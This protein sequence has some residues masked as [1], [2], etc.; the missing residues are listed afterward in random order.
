MAAVRAARRQ[1][2][3]AERVVG[4]EVQPLERTLARFVDVLAAIN[5]ERRYEL[6][7]L[8]EAHTALLVE[9][10]QDRQVIKLLEERVVGL[11]WVLLVAIGVL[12]I[13]GY[14]ALTSSTPFVA[15]LSSHAAATTTTTAATVANTTTH[16]V[17][18]G[19]Y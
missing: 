6:R 18:G 3:L 11:T 15:T 12:F 19:L 10:R 4:G 17:M 8:K 14:V 5:E 16:S 2:M 13:L 7:S 9:A 1:S